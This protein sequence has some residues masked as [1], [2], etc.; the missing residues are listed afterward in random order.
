M[1]RHRDLLGN[2][3]NPIGETQRPVGQLGEPS[4]LLREPHAIS[5][6]F[7]PEK[8]INEIGD[9]NNKTLLN[10][11]KSEL[12]WTMPNISSKEWGSALL[13]LSCSCFGLTLHKKPERLKDIFIVFNDKQVCMTETLVFSTLK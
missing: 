1:G 5:P 4:W 8:T 3:G 9:F 7:S 11:I 6:V 13:I 10:S 2:S 12:L